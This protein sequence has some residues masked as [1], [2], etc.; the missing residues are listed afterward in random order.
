MSEAPIMIS[1]SAVSWRTRLAQF[2]EA[3]K[4]PFLA[5]FAAFLVGGVIIWITSG[6]LM[7]V[8][9]AYWGM[10]RGAFIKPRAFSET[11]VAT[12][13]Y[14]LLS[15]AVGVGF[16]AGLFNIGVEGQFFIGAITTAWVGQAFHGLPAIIH[17]PLTLLAG[18]LGGAIWAAIPGYLKARTGAHEVITTMM[19]NYIAFRLQE[20]IVTFRLKDPGAG[21]VQTPPVSHAAEIWTMAAVPER[22]KDPLNALMVALVFG[23]IFLLIGRWVVGLPRMQERLQTKLQRRLVMWGIAIL[24]TILFFVVLPPLTQLWWPFQDPYDRLHIGLFIALGTA[25]FMWWLLEKTTLGFELRTVGANLNAARYSGMSITRNIMFAMVLSGAI[26]GLAG[27]IEVLGV[28]TCR[29]VQVAFV[30]GYGWDSIAIAL[31]A[32]NNPFGI[33][34]ASFLWGAMRNGADLMEL[35]SGV[36]KYIISLIQGL[37]LLFIAAPGIIRWVFRIKGERKP[38]EAPLTHGWGGG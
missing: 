13:P 26:A 31:L 18:M 27:S 35:S 34:A 8:V 30:S 19:M 15:L 25:V 37:V 21:L 14:I 36:S 20:Y 17:L 22:L 28:S 32:K 7:T 23:F 38:E 6:S 1:P 12:T 11:L 4:I 24:A 2:W 5:I 33:I 9:E 16:K 10:I 29:C 3:I